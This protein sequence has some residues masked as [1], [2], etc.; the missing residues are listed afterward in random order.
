MKVYLDNAATTPLAPE[1]IDEMIFVMKNVYGNP[2]SIHNW[3]REA[4]VVIENARKT[5]ATLI[6]AS[7]SEIYFTSGA[8][9]AITTILWGAI[10]SLQVRTIITSKIEHSIVIHTLDK[11]QERGFVKVEYCKTDGLGHID[12]QHLQTLT[13]ANNGA[14]VVLMHVNNEIGNISPINEISLMCKQNQCYY[15]TDMVQ[16]MGKLAI[17]LKEISPDF[18]ISSGH[19]LHAPKGI[20]FMYIRKGVK[21]QPLL[22]GGQ[23]MNQRAGTENIYGIAGLSKAF[24]IAYMNYEYNVDYI[25][26]LKQY[27]I[28]LLEKIPN[29]EFNGDAKGNSLYTILN[30][31]FPNE[32]K[33]EMLVYKLDIAGIAVSEGSACS[34]GV[35][36]LSH[37]IQEL[38]NPGRPAIRFSFSKFNTKEEIDYCIEI[39]RNFN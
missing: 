23:E 5:I 4:K 1:V 20:G 36:H 16:S 25:S 15:C 32:T 29:I 10:S 28:Q 18:A 19:K 21:I 3:G 17:N 33:Y 9:E 34:S 38:P 31:S 26:G 27:M 35:N 2:S 11:F 22:I 30:V 13:E 8:V 24:E 37:V 14:L 12:L 7:P 6:Q 39:I